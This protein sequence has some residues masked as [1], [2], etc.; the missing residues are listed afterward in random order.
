MTG[1]ELLQDA[2]ERFPAGKWATDGQ[3]ALLDAERRLNRV[4]RT[5][6]MLTPVTLVLT[7]GVAD[8]PADFLEVRSLTAPFHRIAGAQIAGDGSSL[9]FD[10]YAALPSLLTVP[11]NWLSRR[12]PELYV[13]AIL[14]AAMMKAGRL[15][16]AQVAESEVRRLVA[17]ENAAAA[18]A[19]LSGHRMVLGA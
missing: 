12:N 14:R 2:A 6:D 18:Q 7:A 16:A 17:E 11:D 1:A 4:L 3:R 15:D 9:T 19:A 8:L 10:Y 13:Q 5:G